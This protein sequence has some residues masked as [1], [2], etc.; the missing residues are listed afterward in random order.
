[1]TAETASSTGMP[2]AT[3]APNTTSSRISV[4]GTEVASAWPKFSDWPIAR[5]M[6][7][8]PVSAMRRP[9]WRAC[10]AAT[11]CWSAATIGSVL[12]LAYGTWKVTRALRPSAET[13]DAPPV[14]S[15]D[16][17]LPASLGRA[18]RDAA[19]SRAACCRLRLRAN[20]WPGV[21]A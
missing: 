8:S 10:T 19:T 5:L 7:P 11:A 15:G 20:V 2:A 6:L 9:G 1:M 4:M 21:R 14:R 12:P 18:L 16:L 17:M 13:R 3:R